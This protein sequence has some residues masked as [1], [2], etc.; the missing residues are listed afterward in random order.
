MKTRISRL[1]LAAVLL[2][3][4][5]IA[6]CAV[7]R[8]GQVG[9]K[10]TLGKLKTNPINPGTKLFNPF[11]SKILKINVR[12]V[13]IYETLPL[14]TKEGLSVQAQITLLYHVKPESVRDVYI[15]YGRN[16]E[17]VF[18]VSNFLAT[19]REVS[20]RYFAKELYA[21]DREKVE[22]VIAE[23]L[24]ADLDGKGFQVDAVLLKD[25]IL[26]PSMSQAIQDK[27]NAEQ[28]TLQMEFTIEK[29]KKEAERQFIEAEGIKRAQLI[30]DSSLTKELLQ[31]NYIQM[32]K[33]LVTSPNAKVIITDG[34]LPVIV[35]GE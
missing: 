21:I 34:K 17:A 18:V 11:V 35:G 16:Y 19:A 4:I 23:E 9:L 13:E 24:A 30:I 31:Y 22:S 3:G 6:G 25:I 1:G 28:A 33:G 7:I 8:P 10:Q 32:M 29:Q 12:T 2:T 5:A 20:A 27:V 15:N 26:P 14:P